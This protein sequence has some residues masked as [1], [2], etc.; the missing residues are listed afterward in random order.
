MYHCP[1][2]NLSENDKKYLIYDTAHWSVF[3]SDK[4]DY[5]G[6]CIVV[7][8]SHKESLSALS[9]NEWDDLK[10][11]VD[12]IEHKLKTKLG[13][14]MFNWSCLMNDAYKSTPPCP[15]VH[16]HVRPRYSA[17]LTIGNYSFCDERFAHHYDNKL[18]SDTTEEIINLIYQKLK[19]K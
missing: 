4:Q 6:R 1:F 8:N 5:I 11:V 3:L 12:D 10:N 14:T 16:L 18:E 13:A 2:C 7:L 15:H 19:N 9:P 17:L